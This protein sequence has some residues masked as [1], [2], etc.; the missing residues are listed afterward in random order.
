MWVLPL[1]IAPQTFLFTVSQIHALGIFHC[2]KGSI[3]LTVLWQIHPQMWQPD[4][5][6]TSPANGFLQSLDLHALC[7]GNMFV[8]SATRNSISTTVPSITR[9]LPTSNS[10]TA[11]HWELS[12]LL[13]AKRKEKGGNLEYQ[14]WLL[15]IHC[16]TGDVPRLGL[17]SS[18]AKCHRASSLP[19][20][21]YFSSYRY[22]LKSE[23]RL[24]HLQPCPFLHSTKCTVFMGEQA[25]SAETALGNRE[26]AL[27]RHL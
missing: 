10:S 18:P 15:Q 24:R 21:G 4:N 9:V 8:L 3:F 16:G 7:F 2:Q 25:E 17:R 13:P 19:K 5:S 14:A 6:H 1:Q 11:L 22:Y 27:L 20:L 26:Q 12:I 23:I